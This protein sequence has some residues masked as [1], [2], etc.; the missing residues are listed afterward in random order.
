MAENR[1]QTNRKQSTQDCRLVWPCDQQEFAE[2]PDAAAQD[3]QP[4]LPLC[5]GVHPQQRPLQSLRQIRSP[6]PF[7]AQAAPVRPQG[8]DI[9]PDDPADGHPGRLPRVAHHRLPPT[10]RWRQRRRAKGAHGGVQPCRV[11]QEDLHALNTCWWPGVEPAGGRHGDTVRQRLQP[12]AGPAGTKQSPQ[13]RTNQRSQGV[14]FDHVVARRGAG[15]AQGTTQTRH[16]RENHT[17]WFVRHRV[18]GEGASGAAQ[19]AIRGQR[20][21]ARGTSHHTRT[22]EQDAGPF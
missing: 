5:R 4:P 21:A 14:S 10:R 18:D 1:L 8:V 15:A 13:S 9:L 16:R 19:V 6:R 20:T 17:G 22:V 11:E 7:A 3:R 2:P 12:P